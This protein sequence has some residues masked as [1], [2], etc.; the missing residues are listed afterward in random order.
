MVC[1][2]VNEAVVEEEAENGRDGYK[3]LLELF[4]DDLPHDVLDVGT[5]LGVV[6]LLELGSPWLCKLAQ[7]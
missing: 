6:V 2:Y 3:R 1:T 4:R 5:G 7:G